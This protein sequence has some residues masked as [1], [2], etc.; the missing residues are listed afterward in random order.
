ML[1]NLSI[2][3]II[4]IRLRCIFLTDCFHILV[5]HLNGFHFMLADGS[6]PF[7]CLLECIPLFSVLTSY[8]MRTKALQSSLQLFFIS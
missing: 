7:K 3:I 6:S 1:P 2:F 4:A 5:V 8:T